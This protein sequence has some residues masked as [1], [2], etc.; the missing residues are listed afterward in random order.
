M[1]LIIGGKYWALNI[2][3]SLEL[4]DLIQ[5]W[6]KAVGC[7]RVFRGNVQNNTLYLFLGQYGALKI[8]TKKNKL[9]KKGITFNGL[10]L[11]LY[12]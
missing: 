10:F 9:R 8:K 2:F 3:K 7:L 1:L 6:A 5:P 12:F 11:S 4:R